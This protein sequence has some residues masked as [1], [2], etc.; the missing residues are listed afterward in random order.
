VKEEAEG[1]LQGL[2]SETE[3]LTLKI[4]TFQLSIFQK[5]SAQGPSNFVGQLLASF[6]SREL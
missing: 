5:I 3:R 2:P 4:A 1:L 6:D